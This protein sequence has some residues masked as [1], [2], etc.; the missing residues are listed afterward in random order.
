MEILL[1]AMTGYLVIRIVWHMPTRSSNNDEKGTLAII[2][3]SQY[4]WRGFGGDWVRR[5]FLRK[6]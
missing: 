6:I 4:D 2:R 3:F 1:I 5:C